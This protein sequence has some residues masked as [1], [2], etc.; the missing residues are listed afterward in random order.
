M[1]E[2]A[3]AIA[4]QA[5]LADETVV[6]AIKASK[7][8]SDDEGEGGKKKDRGALGKGNQRRQQVLVALMGKLKSS[9]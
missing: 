8:P 4:I 3:A 2:S 1:G 5:I 6:E 9:S 7:A